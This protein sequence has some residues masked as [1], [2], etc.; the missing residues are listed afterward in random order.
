M[1]SQTPKDT[2][3]IA[4]VF[5]NLFRNFP[6][7]ILTNLL[8]AVPLGAFFALF[9]WLTVLF[10]I[11]SDYAVLVQLLM[12]IPVFPFYAGVVKITAK[13]V[14][15][16]E[17]VPVVRTF[18][19]AVKE[20]FLRFLVHGVIFYAAVVFSY[21]SV[22]LY[23][24]LLSQSTLFVGP[25][26][27]SVIVILFFTFMFFYIPAMTVTFDIPMKYIYK[28]SLL[29]SYGELKKN[30][31]ALLG[32]LLVF[33]VSTTFLIACYGS[34]VAVV[35]VTVILAAVLVPSIASFI[36]HSAVYERMY[37]MITDKSSR[38]EAIDA[39]IQE[40]KTGVKPAA[41][42]EMKEALK[43]FEIDESVPDDE[44]IYFNGRMMKKSVI[45]KLKQESEEV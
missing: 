25:L 41:K 35:I 36:I 34:P 37:Q 6:R 11:S 3:P 22:S 24:R 43:N 7:L 31:I 4:A 44:Y 39:K 14:L 26:I 33:V 1:A 18:F 45:V 19:G 17:R 32:L 13:M 30:F 12:V 27:I 28:N 40:T 20:N 9:W 23:I 21:V 15:G 2:L 38:A 10:A 8:F 16:E 5:S 42:D 29:M